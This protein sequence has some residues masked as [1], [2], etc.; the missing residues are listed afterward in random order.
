MLSQD[1]TS[2]PELTQVRILA[3]IGRITCLRMLMMACLT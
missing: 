1:L 3:N 2:T